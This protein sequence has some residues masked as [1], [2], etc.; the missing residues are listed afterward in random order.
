MVNTCLL[1][2]D[3]MDEIEGV[4]PK[5]C[6]ISAVDA[7][8]EGILAVNAVNVALFDE[9]VVFGNVQYS[10]CSASTMNSVAW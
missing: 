4:L 9:I 5:C 6:P 2:K 1:R 7:I 3:G 8:V 10:D